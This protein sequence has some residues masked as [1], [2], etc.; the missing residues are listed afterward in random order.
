MPDRHLELGVFAPTIGCLPPQGPAS[1]MLISTA[2]QRTEA[3]FDYNRRLAEMLDQAGLEIFFMAQRASAGFGPSGFWTTSLDSLTTAAALAMVTEQ[4]KIISTVHPAFFHPG[5]IARIGATI[6]QISKGRWGMNLVSGWVEK[7]FHMLDIPLREHDERYKL[8]AE[9][10]EILEKFWTTDGFDY[11]GQYF[12]IRQ[13]KCNPKPVQRPRPPFYNAG[14]STTGKEFTARY[15]DWYF[16]GAVTPEQAK[17]EIADVRARAAK[18]GREVR[19]LTYIF[20]LCRDSEEQACK[21]VEEIFAHADYEGAREFIEALT[22]QTLGTANSVLGKG[23][24]EE[25]LRS[26]VLSVGSGK[27][28]GTPEQV[29]QQLAQLQEAGLDGV[30]L[31]FRHVEEE[32]A[33]FIDKVLPLLEQMGVRRPRA[34]QHTTPLSQVAG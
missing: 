22:G 6:D 25:M 8:S 30:G 29:T 18:Y 34:T 10:V 17:A 3:T 11:D 9:F 13:G 21:E 32:M 26:A 14:S 2:E 1:F 31:T 7:D 16:T 33:E 28:I 5:M 24:I 20:V 27:L 4:I 15:C 23:E 19:F 12:T